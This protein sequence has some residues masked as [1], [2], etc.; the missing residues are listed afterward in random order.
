MYDSAASQTQATYEAETAVLPAALELLKGSTRGAGDAFSI[1]NVQCV[2]PGKWTCTLRFYMLG[3]VNTFNERKLKVLQPR[4]PAYHSPH[5]GFG[6][7]LFTMLLRL[8]YW[9]VRS[10][11]FP[12]DDPPPM[13]TGEAPP[14][15]CPDTLHGSRPDQNVRTRN[16]DSSLIPQPDG[17]ARRSWVLYTSASLWSAFLKHSGFVTKPSLGKGAKDITWDLQWS[18]PT[19]IMME[20]AAETLGVVCSYDNWRQVYTEAVTLPLKH[21]PL[22]WEPKEAITVLEDDDTSGLDSESSSSSASQAASHNTSLAS[23][24]STRSSRLSKKRRRSS[25]GG[26][27]ASGRGGSDRSAPK[28]SSGGGD[29]ASGRGGSG[30]SAPKRSSASSSEQPTSSAP[31][32]GG[33]PGLPTK[34]GEIRPMVRDGEKVTKVHTIAPPPSGLTPSESQT[35]QLNALPKLLK[36]HSSL[37]MSPHTGRWVMRRPVEAPEAL[38]LHRTGATL[39]HKQLPPAAGQPQSGLRYLHIVR[40]QT[41]FTLAL[42]LDYERLRAGLQPMKLLAQAQKAA[43]SAAGTMSLVPDVTGS[44]WLIE[45]EPAVAK[46]CVGIVDPTGRGAAHWRVQWTGPTPGQLEK[47]ALKAGIILSK[48]TFSRLMRKYNADRT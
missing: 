33:L 12:R 30:R 25:G 26:D 5:E 20:R 1:R 43:A 40:G 27:A 13:Q 46:A 15:P 37:L 22:P 39:L 10:N 11:D 47:A 24:P 28:R 14:P 4:E 16:S 21:E 42:R 17:K 34:E 29:A 41:V 23:T 48:D 18:G 7:S 32:P 9:R 45:L 36:L 31:A 3:S 2:S 19:P 35:E 6:T 38:K 44:S 8:D